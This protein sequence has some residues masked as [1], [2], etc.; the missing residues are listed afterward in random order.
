[1]ASTEWLYGAGHV[2][3]RRD[4]DWTP[5]TSLRRKP[6]SPPQGLRL[7][8]SFLQVLAARRA[9]ASPAGSRKRCPVDQPVEL[10]PAIGLGAVASANRTSWRPCMAHAPSLPE[11]L[12]TSSAGLLALR[13]CVDIDSAHDGAGQRRTAAA[14]R[15]GR[16]QDAVVAGRLERRRCAMKSFNARS[17][18]EIWIRDLVGA[19]PNAEDAAATAIY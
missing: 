11:S 6:Q 2:R 9:G 13:A 7:C 17:R 8:R 1:M 16:H 4:R 12:K 19:R 15:R 14:N 10:P 5:E 3:K 18:H